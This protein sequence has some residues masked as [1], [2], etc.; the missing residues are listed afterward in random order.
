MVLAAMLVLGVL[1]LGSPSHAQP[2]PQAAAEGAASSPRA[3]ATVRGSLAPPPAPPKRARAAQTVG[4]LMGPLRVADLG[5]PTAGIV[6]K[7]SVDVGDTVSSGQVLATLRSEVESAGERAAR[8]RLSLEADLRA[9]QVKLDLARLRATRA[10]QLLT[11]GFIS[12]QAAEQA[13]AELR[14]AEQQLAQSLGQRE[15]L[16]GDL[17]VVRA[18]V[19]QRTVRAPFGGTVVER[20]REVGERVED[21]PLLRLAQLDPLRVDLIVPA[22]RFG[23]YRVGDSVQVHPEIAGVGPVQAKVTH[24]DVVID[25]ASNTFRV[26]LSLPNPGRKLPAGARCSLE[27]PG[28]ETPE[29]GALP[30]RGSLPAAA[31]PALT[32]VQSRL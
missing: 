8:T 14:V 15:V 17:G 18:Q 13:Q 2:A 9:S 12:P 25:A 31:P 27:A 7:L 30:M 19:E 6:D 22:P 29:A 3:T 10:A 23:Q 24:V 28:A 11:E 16:A 4:C 20:F 5:A 1:L 26:R 21:R 32:P